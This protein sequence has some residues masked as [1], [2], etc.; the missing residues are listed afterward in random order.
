MK[1]RWTLWLFLITHAWARGGHFRAE[2]KNALL[3]SDLMPPSLLIQQTRSSNP[4]MAYLASA[5]N[6]S[7]VSGA[8][9]T[10]R[11]HRKMMN[12]YLCRGYMAQ[13][14]LDQLQ[15]DAN[16]GV[17]I[18]QE[19]RPPKDKLQRRGGQRKTTKPNPLLKDEGSSNY[20]DWL[21]RSAVLEDIYRRYEHLSDDEE[22]EFDQRDRS[23]VDRDDDY[24][25]EVTGWALEQPQLQTRNPHGAKQDHHTRQNYDEDERDFADENWDNSN[26]HQVAD[27]ESSGHGHVSGGSSAGSGL[28]LG[29]GDMYDVALTAIAILAFGIFILNVFLGILLPTS[30]TR[31]VVISNLTLPF[32]NREGESEIPLAK[33]NDDED[34]THER[35]ARAI[36]EEPEESE[37]GAARLVLI[38]IKAA[39]RGNPK[40]LQSALCV[41]NKVAR[42]LEGAAKL[43]VPVWS[44]GMS[45][46]GRRGGGSE[47]LGK[48]VLYARALEN[49]R[50]STLGLAG[51]KCGEI[52]P[53][54]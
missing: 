8:L 52:F 23:M 35:I 39:L 24:D 51:V 6:A 46:L 44:L 42:K 19:D 36:S 20:K 54:C 29:I 16:E 14:I 10:M 34:K 41:G 5:V 22:E 26:P 47:T 53:P 48:S 28:Q 30:S 2:M 50:A 49:L 21:S 13:D 45:W 38:T 31:T 4:D 1:V 11:F 32:R 12:E 3:N 27:W 37:E 40:C 33:L 43:W 18:E 25:A 7:T 15:K 9:N 17:E